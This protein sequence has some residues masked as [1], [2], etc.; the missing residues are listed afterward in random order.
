MLKEFFNSAW[1]SGFID[2]YGS[3]QIRSTEKG[4]DPLKIEA[5]F[6][7]T[8]SEK[9]EF[10]MQN[11]SYFLK[12]TFKSISNRN[13][14]K[15]RT[16]S[17]NNNLILIEYLNKYPLL[18]SKYLDYKDW[19]KCINIIKNKEHLTEEGINKIKQIK[20]RINSNRIYFNWDH[21]SYIK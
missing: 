4:K 13:Q 16:T 10:I 18:S 11:I 20:N 5:R 17:L 15:I 14:I 12:S 2:A 8:Q 7:I 21:L 9:N 3:F 19:E 1:L 6:E